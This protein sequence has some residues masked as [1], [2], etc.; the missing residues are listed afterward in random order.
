MSKFEQSQEARK[1][2]KAGQPDQALSIYR[3]IWETYPEERNEW[4]A[5]F[6]LK[7]LKECKQLVIG[8]DENLIPDLPS[9]ET[10]IIE[11]FADSERVTGIYAWV[12]YYRYIKPF[13]E[14]NPARA[15]A[16]VE[17]MLEIVGQKDMTIEENQNYP[18]PATMG[19]M[20]LLK[21]YKKP[22]LN[23]HKTSYWL[24]KIDPEKLNRQSS[25]YETDD[26][27]TRESASDFED[28]CSLKTNYLFKTEQYQTCIEWC[29][30]ALSEVSKF[31]YDNDI[32]FQR[33]QA[34]SLTKVGANEE[35]ETIF[36]KILESKNGEKWFI[37]FEL[38]ELYLEEKNY[39][40]ALDHAVKAALIGKDYDKKVRL[41]FNMSRIFAFRKQI[42]EGRM[43]AQLVKA[44]LTKFEFGEKPEYQ[45]MYNYF[46]L[47]ENSVPFKEI[48][49]QCKKCWKVVAFEGRTQYLGKIK[50][51]HKSGKSGIV[52]TQDGVEYFFAV[53][54]IINDNPHKLIAEAEVEFYLKA[55]TDPQGN[56][57]QHAEH[58]KVTKWPKMEVSSSGLKIGDQLNGVIDGIAP[59]GLF[60]K[61]G[62]VTGLLHRSK[63]PDIAR[64]EDL[65]HKFCQ[66]NNISVEV[67]GFRE[68]KPNFGCSK[69]IKPVKPN[70]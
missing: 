59:F 4:D 32:W 24:E 58:L 14:N 68:G 61:V 13:D 25:P 36:E 57:T 66:G 16:G 56:P 60:V 33:R 63:I 17:K 30:K 51:L 2:L 44:V 52:T 5:Y 40:K 10:A 39:E 15:E 49:Q 69:I 3:D 47:D 20:K 34:L 18:C 41:F 8:K 1:L 7:A 19:V 27:K 50:Y 65:S 23:I 54:D 62:E 42:K 21:A 46:K 55:A 38:S 64:G 26:G 48:L 22:N 28:Y 67:I 9:W 45:E 37:E 70:S 12:L 35:A 6:G 29:E 53:R 31:H 11:Q 43:H